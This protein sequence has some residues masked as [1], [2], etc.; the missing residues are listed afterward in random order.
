MRRRFFSFQN[1]FNYC[2]LDKF[3]DSGIQAVHNFFTERKVIL[4]LDIVKNH[5]NIY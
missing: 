3:L 5:I 2:V 1:A 4:P